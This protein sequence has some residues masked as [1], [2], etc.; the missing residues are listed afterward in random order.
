VSDEPF[1]FKVRHVEQGAWLNSDPEGW[2][3]GLP[4]QCDTW[5]I[6]PGGYSP[7]PQAEAL[8]AL[9]RFIAEAQAAREA[10]APAREET[11]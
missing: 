1:G 6:H 9:D 10:L 5:D 7:S 8:A 11:T 4:H 2:M 3:V